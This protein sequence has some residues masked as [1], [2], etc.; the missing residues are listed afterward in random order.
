MNKK[1]S[2]IVAEPDPQYQDLIGRELAAF[3]EFI[4]AYLCKGGVEAYQT[5]QALPELDLLITEAVMSDLDGINLLVNVRQTRPNLPVIVLSEYDLSDYASY[6]GDAKVLSKPFLPGQ[7]QRLMLQVIPDLGNTLTSPAFAPQ[8][9]LV[10][11]A[12][13]ATTTNLQPYPQAG[14]A[15]SSERAATPIS[16]LPSIAASPTATQ[17]HPAN[18]LLLQE[19]MQIS[20][21]VLQQRLADTEWGPA[22]QASQAGV[23]RPAQIIF[24]Q[25]LGTYSAQ[26]FINYFTQLAAI[27]HPNLITIIELGDF[28]GQPFVAQELWPGRPLSDFIASQIQ[29]DSRQ[30]AYLAEQALNALRQLAHIP[31]R[32]ITPS[33]LLISNTGV[34]KITHLHPVPGVAPATMATQLSTLATI[35][36]N[37]LNPNARA[38]PRLNRLLD[39]M[40]SGSVSV[41][42]AALAF[43]SL[44]IEMAPV[45][46]RAET[47]EAKQI[48]AQ[49][50]KEE[51]SKR[52]GLIILMLTMLTVTGA[53]VAFF[54]RDAILE[55]I[56][57]QQ[58]KD[59]TN[60]MQ[61][62]PAGIVQMEMQDPDN[63]S[64]TIPMTIST[65]EFWIG[66]FEVT[67]YEYAQFIRASRQQGF[68]RASIIHPDTPPTEDF[69]PHNWDKILAAAQKN[70]FFGDSQLT[71]RSPIFNV[72]YYSAYAYAKWRGKRL[73]TAEEWLK[74]ARGQQGFNY[75]WGNEFDPSAANIGLDYIPGDPRKGGEKDGY[76]GIAPVDSARLAKDTSPFGVR[77]MYG[78]VM[79]WTSSPG[80]LRLGRETMRV[81]GNSFS[82]EVE[83]PL[84]RP[85]SLPLNPVSSNIFTGFRLASDKPPEGN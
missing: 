46:Q 29:L 38:E 77:Q 31:C 40:I 1:I 5:S 54:Y 69:I 34:L 57:S 52:T 20:S 33:D 39:A 36:R 74:A 55:L 18:R 83:R 79:E 12:T 32:Q 72:N 16:S 35:L 11:Q 47:Q 7:L 13:P 73:P 84:S 6:L 81:M 80:G 65:P 26:E 22:F 19:G 30:A 15:I 21:Y 58:G 24:Y 8:Q 50:E 75:P 67:I 82:S 51:R 61:R 64:A 27:P 23:N 63:P 37:T 78:N 10:P 45:Q 48:A 41:E 85:G 3:S 14:Q 70:G 28:A 9:M 42:Q 2:I 71:P 62:I 43:H 60:D 68:D 66:T 49:I 44:Q 17:S 56:G 4:Q 59:F 25:N 76:N 53:I